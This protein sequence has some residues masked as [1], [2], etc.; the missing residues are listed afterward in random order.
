MR[1]RLALALL[2]A[3]ATARAKYMEHHDLASL[4]AESESVVLAE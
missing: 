1:T 3:A 4:V 2:L